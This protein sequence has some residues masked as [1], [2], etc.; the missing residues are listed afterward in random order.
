MC[1][2]LYS[3]NSNTNYNNNKIIDFPIRNQKPKASY[4]WLR[5][6]AAM[7]TMHTLRMKYTKQQYMNTQKHI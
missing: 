1:P 4:V 7:H 3:C 2:P 5:W 6:A